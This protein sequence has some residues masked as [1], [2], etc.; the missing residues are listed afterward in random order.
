MNNAEIG[1]AQPILIPCPQC[2][3]TNRV[4]REKLR[5]GTS[6]ACGKCK[7]SLP[8]AAK[9]IVLTDQHFATIVNPSPVPVLIDAWAPWCGPCR[10]IAPLI[11]QLARDF[12]GDVLVAKL[13]V[14]ENPQTAAR[15]DFRSIP[16]L[17]VLQNG[18]EVHRIV[19][20]HPRPVILRRLDQAFEA[21]QQVAAGGEPQRAAR[22]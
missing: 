12:A 18:R 6:S 14:D 9:P 8:T 19:G 13:N 10:V 4:P 5:A 22:G 7:A 15:F 3:A 11:E 20:V 1:A 2:G 17:L 21:A 16:T